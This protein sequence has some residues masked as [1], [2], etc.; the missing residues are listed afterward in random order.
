MPVAGLEPARIAPHDFESCASAN[1]ATPA[2]QISCASYILPHTF[3]VCNKNFFDTQNLIGY[4]VIINGQEQI[5]KKIVLVDGH[6]ILNRAFYGIPDLTDGKGRHTNAVYGFLNILFKVIDEEQPD[7][8]TVAFDVKQKTFRHEMFS[9]YKGT[10]K[11]MPAELHEQVPII[12]DVLRAMNICVVTCP[13]YEADDILGTISVNAQNM[14]YLTTIISGDRDLLQLVTDKVKLRIPKTR[15]GKTV[16]EDYD[17]DT[18]REVYGLSPKQIIDLKGLMGDSSDNIPGLPGV[19]EKTAA[20]LLAEY[21]TVENVIEHAEEIKPN[22]AKNAVMEHKELAI[23]SKKLATI[24]TDCVIDYDINNAVIDDMFNE[25][26]YHLIK[27][28]EFKSMLSKFSE[29]GMQ[30]DERIEYRHITDGSEAKE[31][32]CEMCENV[33]QK[34]EYLAVYIIRDNENV[35][36][37]VF[38][39]A[40]SSPIFVEA[41]DIKNDVLKAVTES[42]TDIVLY[43]VKEQLDILDT[44]YTPHIWDAHIAAYLINP[45]KDSYE[46]VDIAKDFLDKEIAEY[47]EIFG[48]KTIKSAFADNKDEYIDYAITQCRILRDAFPKLIEKLKDEDMYGL[49]TDIEMPLLYSLYHMEK[50]GIRVNKEAFCSYF[51]T[52]FS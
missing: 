46:G 18:V 28:L 51:H 9:E 33:L 52:F 16:V 27:E 13:G 2:W 41:G 10:R 3:F 47:S 37:A 11:P 38:D 22:K 25:N 36:G 20:K 15:G 30:K 23:L 34:D 4:Y 29:T 8:L 7:L 50:E 19:G 26:A 1:S 12:Q 44:D 24:K 21:E 14:G 48:K 17:P 35:Y 6:S 42:G 43:N 49:Y 31:A 32:V 39:C 5:M 45:L 40:D